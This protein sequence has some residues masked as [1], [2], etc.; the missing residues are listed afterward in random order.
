[1]NEDDA[2]QAPISGH[3]F[4][5]SLGLLFIY[6]LILRPLGL[7]EVEDIILLKANI[8]FLFTIT[9]LFSALLYNYIYSQ[10]SSE[11]LK[12]YE[13][14]GLFSRFKYFKSWRQYENMHTLCWLGKDWSWNQLDPYTWVIFLVPTVLIGID[15]IIT[16]HKSRRMTI[17]CLHYV[18]QLMWVFGNMC[19]ALSEIFL[20][21]ESDSP[22]VITL[23]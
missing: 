20:L 13:D 7:I 1:M 23:V 14:V 10:P 3:I 18:A 2:I 21:G 15:F 6:H 5:A 11:Q 8:V 12:R 19:W 9:F 16:T 22:E 4:E 17:D